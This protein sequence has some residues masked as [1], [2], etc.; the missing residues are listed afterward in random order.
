MRICGHQTPVTLH[1]VVAADLPAG[2]IPFLKTLKP[3]ITG[4]ARPTD[5]ARIGTLTPHPCTDQFVPMLP[6]TGTQARDG[7]P[8]GG[9]PPRVAK[10]VAG[11]L[12]GPAAA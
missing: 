7:Q 9:I 11:V 1:R 8:A 4:I 2:H 6:S 10:G 3:P 12:L 5:V